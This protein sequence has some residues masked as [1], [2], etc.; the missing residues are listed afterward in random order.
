[1]PV[2]YT[3]SMLRPH[4]HRY[5]VALDIHAVESPVLDLALPVWTPGSY[6]IRDYARHVQQFAAADEHGEPLPWR[7]IDKTTWCI[8]A[9]N[10]R[11]VRVT[12]QVYAFDLSVRTSHLDGT[13]G[14]FNPVQISVCICAGT[15]MIRASS[16]SR[17]RL[18]GR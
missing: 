11:S 9:G 4:T 15:P 2:T 13:H 5:D 8:T 16:M 12:Y 10:A 14:Y 3:I 6:L 17:R 1:M 18:D 7:K